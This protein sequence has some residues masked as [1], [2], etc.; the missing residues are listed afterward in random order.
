MLNMDLDHLGRQHVRIGVSYVFFAMATPPMGMLQAVVERIFTFPPVF[1]AA[2]RAARRKIMQRGQEMGVW[3]QVATDTEDWERRVQLARNPDV[4][5][6]AYYEAPFH[7]YERGNLSIDAALEVANAAKSVHATVFQE[8]GQPELLDPNG[9]ERLRTSFSDKTKEAL[10]AFGVDPACIRD[11]LDIGAATGLSSVALLEAFP[12][13]R[14]VRGIDLSQ[15]FVAVGRYI[16]RDLVERGRL[17][18]EHAAAEDLGAIV[19]DASQDLVS[20][21]LV[22]HEL[23]QEATRNIFA[24]AH[25]TLRP[26]GVLAIME[27]DPTTPAF[28][29]VMSNPVP[30]TVFKA[31]EPYL[32]EYCGLDMEAELRRAGF[33]KVQSRAGSPRHK[34]VVALKEFV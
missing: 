12:G 19:P 1:N 4:T 8:P 9:D 11:V 27:M 23:P 21:C 28:R 3:E 15:Y 32:L 14:M 26:G 22:C 30:Y 17:T 6:P 25:R 18:L 2:S 16:H 34:V 7:A 20:M 33:T 24:E 13:S 29:R 31:T 10:D 5:V